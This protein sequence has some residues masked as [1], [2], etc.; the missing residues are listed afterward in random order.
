M[1][2]GVGQKYESHYDVFDPERY[3]PQK[4]QRVNFLL[5]FI[6]IYS[7][8]LKDA[9][10]GKFVVNGNMAMVKMCKNIK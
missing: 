10:K 1:R 3:G 4:S 8:S 2:Y 5:L 6:G 7:N 9:E